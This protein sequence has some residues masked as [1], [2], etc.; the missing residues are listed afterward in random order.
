MRQQ[1]LNSVARSRLAVGVV[2]VALLL[3]TSAGAAEM[4]IERFRA[5]I[6]A[7]IERLGPASNGLVTWVG[8]DAFD[9]RQDGEALIAVIEK[10]RLS[11]NTQQAG[12][13]VLD[14]IEIRKIARNEG[15]LIELDFA[16][17][18][19]IRFR[20]TDGPQTRI[21]LGAARAKVMVE[22]GSKRARETAVEV[23]SAHIDQSD[24][25][26]S[27]SLGPLSIAS[28]LSAE[29]NGGWSAPLEF[30]V[31]NV[32]YT[33]PRAL[34]SGRID[35]IAI[36]SSS[37]GPNFNALDKL[38]DAIDGL[39]VHDSRSPQAPNTAFL[40]T[41][42]AISQP[43]S[44][45]HEELALE[46]LT[47]SGMNGETLVAVAKAGST[48][49]V[50]GLDSDEAAL[51]FGIRHEGLDLASSLIENW[52]VPRQ[53]I[54]DIGFT[55]LHTGAL[56]KLLHAVSAAAEKQ[57]SGNSERTEQHA[58]QQALEAAEMLNPTFH[59]YEAAFDTPAFGARLTGE[60]KGSPLA[61]TGYAA[62]GDLAVRGLDTI[63][64]LSDGT[65][66]AG[67]LPVLREISVKPTASDGAPQL[68]FH[69]SSA[70]PGWLMIN[71]NDV[72][73]WFG[74]V[75]AVADQPRLLKPSDPPMQGG[76]VRSVQRALSA[77]KIMVEEDGVYNSATAGAVARF[78]KEKGINV[79]GV[80]DATT[81]QRLSGVE[82][83]P[84]RPSRN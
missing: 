9:V 60:A 20:E 24:S 49:E 73:A 13:F 37:A 40:A 34:L 17:P 77:A 25:S 79:S 50:T 10:A 44:T 62:S 46:G 26:I 1:F 28:K 43:F 59:I 70:P 21:T 15:D 83:P 22:T 75:E 58:I 51:R 19:Q 7:L 72:S 78:Q 55:E 23:A 41:L 45:L 4:E 36:A 2:G 3:S 6:D 56:A 32:E 31:K 48:I 54:L 67:Y 16:L 71:G 66:F 27:V 80:V 18:K 74:E 52:K 61:P 84:R 57:V 76:D 30:E 33:L 68:R 11:L 5:E 64:N 81:R 65:A 12:Q 39:K 53:A 47:I 63:A 82:D 8:A 35:R 38:R 14:Q 29:P 69:L 42:T